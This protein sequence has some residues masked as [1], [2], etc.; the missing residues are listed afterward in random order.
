MVFCS[1]LLALIILSIEII[2]IVMSWPYSLAPQNCSAQRPGRDGDCY[3]NI[4]FELGANSYTTAKE[5]FET[6]SF[7]KRHAVTPTVCIRTANI[8]TRHV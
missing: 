2:I 6:P 8:A 5:K 7:H 1:I 4:D 3:F